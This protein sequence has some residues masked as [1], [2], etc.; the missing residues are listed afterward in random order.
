MPSRWFHKVGEREIG[1]LTFQ[2]LAGM[3]RSGTLTEDSRVRREHTEEW[4]AAR[5][6]IGLSRAAQT[7]PAAGAAPAES[8]PAPPQPKPDAPK[9]AS[10]AT[11]AQRRRRSRLPV[12]PRTL[13]AGAVGL[14]VVLMVLVVG[15]PWWARRAARRFPESALNRPRPVDRQAL[16]A[17]RAPRPKAPSIPGLEDGKARP[18]PGLEAVD[19]GL[20][21]CLT[22]DLKTIVYAAMPDEA[23]DYDLYIATRDDVSKPFGPPRLIKSCQSPESDAYPTLS[24][25]GLELIFKRS[26]KRS[27]WA[28]RFFRATRQSASSEFG[29]AAHWG[30]PGDDAERR[31]IALPQWLDR[32]HFKFIVAD[33]PQTRKVMIC[34]RPDPKSPFGQ[35]R[36]SAMFYNGWLPWFLAESGLRLY[37]GTPEGLCVVSRQNVNQ[38]FGTEV[39]ILDPSATGPVKGPIWVAPQEDVVFYVSTGPGKKPDVGPGDKGCKLWM[40]R[41]Q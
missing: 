10:S 9:T 16:E 24:A 23:T 11:P 15:Y 3:I 5:D 40:I 17:V 21:P 36:E 35:P 33:T 37:F 39:R 13:I 4:V 31:G 29:P 32:T 20:S 30:V 22:P 28:P 2:D 1:P 14:V 41:L 7:L 26:L 38:S 12:G 25:D 8:Q 34:E 19:P 27:E 6:V 18:I